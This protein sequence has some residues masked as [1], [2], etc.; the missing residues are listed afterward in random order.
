MNRRSSPLNAEAVLQK[1]GEGFQQAYKLAEK[2]EGWGYPSIPEIRPEY[3]LTVKLAEAITGPD[4]KVKLEAP[5]KEI[6]RDAGL[7]F[8]WRDTGHPLKRHKFRPFPFSDYYS[9]KTSKLLDICVREDHA[10]H[11]FLFIEVKLDGKNTAALIKD[12]ERL[13]ELLA[14]FQA[15]G[16]MKLGDLYAVSIFSFH[17][18]DM[19]KSNLKNPH[20]AA[21]TKVRKL[22]KEETGRRPWL[23]YKIGILESAVIEG[24]YGVEDDVHVDGS[25]EQIL[26]HDKYALA[27]VVTLLGNAQDVTNAT[28]CEID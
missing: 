10:E 4:F 15:C 26:V 21:I 19:D 16:A 25:I 14:L 18:E 23:N 27:P 22:L 17:K 20:K 13:I 9:A 28:L 11:P 1:V 2:F 5:I 7:Y 12:L 24:D 8:R 6:L 3:L